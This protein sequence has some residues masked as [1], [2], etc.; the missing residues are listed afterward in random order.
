MK[1]NLLIILLLLTIIF[2][3]GYVSH[4]KQQTLNTKV[5]LNMIYNAQK[6]YKLVNNTYSDSIEKL[7]LQF[8]SYCSGLQLTVNS[9]RFQFTI[10]AKNS[11][12]DVWEA[13]H[14]KQ[15]IKRF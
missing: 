6:H 1:K 5:C 3:Y 10:S 7:A 15:I 13:N 8:P 14:R 11:S 4:K 2:R 9:D 12:S